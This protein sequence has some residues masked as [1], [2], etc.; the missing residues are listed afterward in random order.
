MTLVAQKGLGTDRF[1]LKGIG[2]ITSIFCVIIYN[3]NR[4][5]KKTAEFFYLLVLNM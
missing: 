4:N 5:I 2:I 3:I 1:E